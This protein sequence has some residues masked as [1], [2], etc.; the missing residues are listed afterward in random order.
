MPAS[1]SPQ[2]RRTSARH[3]KDG[4]P[5]KPKP[6]HAKV[7]PDKQ[8]SKVKAVD[9][10]KAIGIH[11]PANIRDKIKK[12]QTEGGN[13]ITHQDSI[14]T[15]SEDEVKPEPSPR[16]RITPRPKST[17][18]NLSLKSANKQD[19]A[20]E[21][22]PEN[23]KIAKKPAHN[24]LDEDVR[25]ASA[26]KK[27]VVSD[28]HWRKNKSQSPS[29]T[30][31]KG[32]TPRPE[33]KPLPKAWVRPAKHVSPL[34]EKGAA[35]G[36]TKTAPNLTPKYTANGATAKPKPS[37]TRRKSRL[38]SAKNDER[39][40]TGGSGSTSVDKSGDDIVSSPTSPSP[41]DKKVESR[42]RGGRGRERSPRAYISVEDQT[43][44]K[45][46]STRKVRE[47]PAYEK[48][49]EDK[50]PGLDIPLEYRSHRKRRSGHR[51]RPAEISPEGS[52]KDL[53]YT[54]KREPRRK[55]YQKEIPDILDY[56]EPPGIPETPPRIFGNPVE[57]W[58]TSTPDPFA[59]SE[60]WTRRT[61]KDSI[62]TSE[63]FHPKTKKSVLTESTSA[64]DETLY[65]APERKSS[66]RKQRGTRNVSL[67]GDT[68]DLED[69][70][71]SNPSTEP[72][73]VPESSIGD[74][75]PSSS[76][77]RSGARRNSHSPTKGR[78]KSS[79]LRDSVPNE[80]VASTVASTAPSSS[81]DASTV[82]FA[83]LPIRSRPDN[84][85]MRR[86]FPSTGKRLSTIASVETFVTKMQAAP[87]S[88]VEGSEF[89]APPDGIPEEVDPSESGDK[90]DPDSLT[91]V[92]RRGTSTKGK[93]ASHADLISVL[94]MPRAGA[95]SKSIMSARSIRTNRSRLATA[96]V[97]DLMNELASDEMK[98]MRELRTLVDGV[99]PVLLTCVLSKSDSAVAA[100]LFSRS[101]QKNDP[102]VTRPIVE[103]GVALERLKTLHKRIPMDDPDALLSWAQSAQ[104]IYSD[105]VKSW[106]LG[107]QDVVV[108]LAPA[109][110][111]PSSTPSR[112][113]AGDAAA[114]DEGLPQNEE[115][116]VVNGDGERVD[117]AF[118][119]KRPLVRLKY[120]AKTLKGINYIKHSEQAEKMSMVFQNLVIDA[121]KRSNQEQARMEDEAAANIDPTRARDPRSLAPLSGVTIDAARCVK[122]RDYFDMHLPHSSGQE[123]DCRV[124]LLL[125]D[126]A[127]GRGNAGDLL[128]CEVDNTGRWLFF[129]PIQ[130][131]RISARNGDLKGEIVVM[132]RGFHS[133]GQEWSE[134]LS[135]KSNDEQAGFE[136]VQMLGLSPIPPQ[137]T[138]LKREKSFVSR[139]PRP[140]SSHASSSLLSAGTGSTPPMKSRTPSPREVE[141]PIG[142]RA[143]PTSKK[144]DYNTPTKSRDRVSLEVSPITPPSGEHSKLKKKSGASPV[145]PPSPL[146]SQ[147]WTGSGPR[148]PTSRPDSRDIDSQDRTPR[149]LNEAMMLAGEGSP[150]GLKRTKA[151]RLSR[152]P[153]HS[154]SAQRA[155]REIILD[156][157]PVPNES[158]LERKRSKRQRSGQAHTSNLSSVPHD[159]KGFSVWMPTSEPE[160]SD[161]SE[162]EPYQMIPTSKRP[163]L[164][165]PHRRASSVPS[166]DL[167]TIPKLR[168]LSQPST[169]VKEPVRGEYS[170]SSPQLSP[171]RV[172]SSAPSKLQ[173]KSPEPINTE[174]IIPDED[175]P[176]PPPPHRSPSPATPVTLK[177]S[178]TPQFTPTLSAF[179]TRRRSSS[180]LKHEYE[181]STA[182]E[183]SEESGEELLHDDQSVTSESSEDE[184]EDD[185]PTPLLPIGEDTNFPKVSPPASIYT[186]PNG[187]ISPSQSASNSPYRAVPHGSGNASKTIASIFSWS[188][189]GKWE[190]LHPDECSIIITPGKIEAYELSAAHSKPLVTDGD[191]IMTTD[192]QGPLVGLELTPLVALRRGTALDISIRSPPMAE[193]R[194][195]TGNNIM[196]RSRSPEEC[197]TLYK[198]MNTSRINNPTYIALQNARPYGQV[199]WAAAMDRQNAARS[200]A[201]SST[202][203][204]WNIGGTLGRRSSYRASSTR[205]ASVSAATDSSVGTMASAF[206][207]LKRF[208][209]GGRLFNVAKSTISSRDGAGSTGSLDSGSA[210]SWSGTSTPNP[211]DTPCRAP[212]APLGITNTKI[213]LYERETQSKW[214]DMGSA[215]LTIMLPDPSTPRSATRQGLGSPGFCQPGS[216]KRILVLGKTKGETLLD[217]TLGETCFE[218]V[219]RTGIAVS[220]WEDVVGKSGVV[221]SVPAVGGVSGARARVYMIQMKTERECAYS[222]SLLGKL[223]Y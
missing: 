91:T 57:A 22:S 165:Q 143:N 43:P 186:L 142:E 103:M 26:P 146:D 109:T 74:G 100:G 99:I 29:K 151:K 14:G 137:L 184:L 197:E 66:K 58:L 163:K 50:S 159:V 161:E 209:G 130:V 41:V 200:T 89:T 44:V 12:W 105:Y 33:V 72:T 65:D 18:V 182:T 114:W 90:F 131:G 45:R 169:P 189:M 157:E 24:K 101:A 173:K 63:L 167:P 170:E 116:Y 7:T 190:S 5:N 94:S 191:E 171:K 71:S 144:W 179:K 185:T 123:V 178:N 188:D 37:G 124:E 194:L 64:Q 23:Q 48:S 222:F 80:D 174:I 93:L 8:Q 195:K 84:L 180:P 214:R 15:P 160:Y 4:S 139:A 20:V 212:G 68:R 217:V 10:G 219:A 31:I 35:Q 40:S 75:T 51:R 47:E 53:L 138:E 172:P 86:I 88:G 110:D 127:P 107:F 87:P 156:D 60:N 150:V 136:W 148:T 70:E 27:R 201:G 78:I 111:D 210:G 198:L 134:V 83:T 52:P 119:L 9:F 95:G 168:K 73:E 102:N 133:G 208:S 223:R 218:R 205:A 213:R 154:P 164:P 147:K 215:R 97:G 220:V 203:S 206:S 17:E 61:S 36:E 115:G 193:S 183:S 85:A 112:T 108:N 113:S 81:V 82:D 181:P 55:S 187:T 19:K 6:P 129:P 121:R 56:P 106:R 118:L 59:D 96:T 175:R 3:D 196:F 16:P 126:D 77:K 49:P 120:L 132:I 42:M 149:S 199:T 125:R 202:S 104:K 216:E 176:P 98:Y 2:N 69:K 30:P 211:D 54:E 145:S 192:A 221:G 140:T 166:L 38:S 39:P 158:K 28:S 122:A 34:K 67:H 76:L 11:E 135:L 79:P 153:T 207:A 141:I 117:V 155:S 25:I 32:E 204:W 13:V 128:L 62:S 162:E 152:N 1:P 177:S 21:A 46:R 92:S